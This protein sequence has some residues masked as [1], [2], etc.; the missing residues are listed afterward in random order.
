MQFILTKLLTFT[1]EATKNQFF[2]GVKTLKL[3][4][5][6]WGHLSAG[7]RSHPRGRLFTGTRKRPRNFCN[8]R[9]V[10]RPIDKTKFTY[11]GPI[12]S[13]ALRIGLSIPLVCVLT[14]GTFTQCTLIH[15]LHHDNSSPSLREIL[16]FLSSKEGLH[17]FFIQNF[18]PT[19]NSFE[20][21]LFTPLKPFTFFKGRNSWNG[22][23]GVKKPLTFDDQTE[24]L[25]GI[26][27]SIPTPMILLPHKGFMACTSRHSPSLFVSRP[28][29]FFSLG[30]LNPKW[31]N[32]FQHA[33]FLHWSPLFSR[34][35]FP[36][37][38]RPSKLF[39]CEF[40]QMPQ[41]LIQKQPP[42]FV[43]RGR[44]FFCFMTH[45]SYKKKEIFILQ[46]KLLIYL[47]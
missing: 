8:H 20:G 38:L 15:R 29:L 28:C 47:Q 42:S 12:Q 43:L 13:D 35:N 22:S 2:S 7:V 6:N 41:I 34:V 30:I 44:K 19:L 36:F 1:T 10:C 26:Q 14:I 37:K 32:C 4:K 25:F 40:R 27:R 45:E 24:C 31:T 39:F 46:T 5:S 33:I 18:Q 23:C 9:L 16:I 21:T 11:K 3:L 17:L